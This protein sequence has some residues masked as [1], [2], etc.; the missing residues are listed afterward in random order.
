MISIKTAAELH[1][2]RRAGA[3]LASVFEEILPMICAGVSASVID[4]KVDALI[5]AHACT[6]SFKSVKGYSHATCISRNEEV[7][8]GIPYATKIFQDGDIVSIDV[9]VCF[10]G[11]HADAA[12]TVAVGGVSNAALDL[13][14][15]TE[16]SF[17]EACK[18][19]IAGN[20]I[21]DVVSALQMCVEKS[22]FSVVRDLCSHGIGRSLHEEPLIPNYGKPGTGFKL[23]PGMTFA[24]EPMVNIGR[25]DV[26]T[27]EDK[28]TI[29]S[30]D[31][32]LSAHYENTIVI[33]PDG[34]PE[35]LTL[36]ES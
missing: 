23:L 32:T 26:L 4:A 10:E 16:A 11:Y 3:V 22:G 20:K 12:R 27:L 28:W 29:I 21:G 31:K 35:I 25:H 36:S 2:M 6:P 7:V 17:F 14:R 19:A 15:V 18:F 34:H 33:S 30:A 1:K 24:L 13:I 9:G 8:H 5:S